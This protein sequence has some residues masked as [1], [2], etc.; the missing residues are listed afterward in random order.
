MHLILTCIDLFLWFP[1]LNELNQIRMAKK[2]MSLKRLRRGNKRK[3][4]KWDK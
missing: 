2:E 3:W 1:N 4:Y